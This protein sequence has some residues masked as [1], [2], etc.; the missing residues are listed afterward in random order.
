MKKIIEIVELEK[1]LNQTR[2]GLETVIGE[3]GIYVS[4]YQEVKFKE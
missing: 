4:S 2:N 3:K 1:L